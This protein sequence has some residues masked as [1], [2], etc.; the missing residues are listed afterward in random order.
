[1]NGINDIDAVVL[2]GGFGTRLRAVV[3]DRP[4]A[5]VSIN[6]CPFVFYLLD[7]LADCGI[8]RVIMCVGYMGREIKNV[9]GHQ[10]REMLIHYSEET[11]PLGTGGALKNISTEFQSDQVLILNG[12]SYIDIDYSEFASWH[13]AKGGIFSIVVTTSLQAERF[14]AVR[15]GPESEVDIFVEKRLSSG[16]NPGWIN[17]GVY[18]AQRRFFDILNGMNA[19]QIS[20]EKEVFPSLIGQGLYG[21]ECNGRFIDIGTP[22]SLI[23]AT[24][25]F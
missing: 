5:L 17:A 6:G 10:Y 1:M 3:S 8:S 9:V 18:L 20:L 12:D 23:A 24:N 22:E 11:T 15:L 4:K 7:Q 14:G 21:Y 13:A 19:D 25:F 2:A 16:E